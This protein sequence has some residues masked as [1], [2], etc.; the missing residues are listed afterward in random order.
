MKFT[1]LLR[2]SC[3]ITHSDPY[4]LALS[5]TNLVNPL[6]RLAFMVVDVFTVG[7]AVCADG[8]WTNSNNLTVFVIDSQIVYVNDV[9]MR[10]L[11]WT[12]SGRKRHGRLWLKPATDTAA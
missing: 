4:A 6:N 3:N 10:T 2:G 9:Y 7:R 5:V 1:H 12:I 8:R 11:M